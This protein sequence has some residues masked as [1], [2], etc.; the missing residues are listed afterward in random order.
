VGGSGTCVAAANTARLG[1]FWRHAYL[2]PFPP[3]RS[4]VGDQPKPFGRVLGFPCPLMRATPLS[5]SAFAFSTAAKPWPDLVGVYST[6][7]VSTADHRNGDSASPRPPAGMGTPEPALSSLPGIFDG[8]DQTLEPLLARENGKPWH[9]SFAH[10]RPVETP[11]E[12][13]PAPWLGR[14]GV[15]VVSWAGCQTP[16]SSIGARSGRCAKSAPPSPVSRRQSRSRAGR[17]TQ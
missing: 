9:G 13:G 12:T 10:V 5:A 4:P 7:S 2:P 3:G 15:Q 1:C 6:L 14:G 8:P 17:V 11:A 16:R